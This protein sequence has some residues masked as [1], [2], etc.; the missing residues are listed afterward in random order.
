[1]Q[2]PMRITFR[3]VPPSPAVEATL[4]EKAAWLEQFCEIIACHVVVEAP[5]RHQH[6]GILYHVRIDLTVSGTVL[7]VNRDPQGA[8]TG[9]SGPAATVSRTRTPSAIASPG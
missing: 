2:V 1:M 9:R 4:R 7:I 5:H 3:D 6:Q 8:A